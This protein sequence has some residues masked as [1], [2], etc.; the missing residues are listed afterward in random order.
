MNA[1]TAIFT[2]MLRNLGP[3]FSY[4]LRYIVGFWLVEMVISTNQKPTKYR[5]L[6]ENTQPEH[7]F[8]ASRLSMDW[9]AENVIFDN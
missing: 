2:L 9:L 1:Y 4:K 5:N 6:F 8:V 7:L 3:I